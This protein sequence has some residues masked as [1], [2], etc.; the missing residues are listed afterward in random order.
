M[1]TIPDIVHTCTISW[2]WYIG[3]CIC[4]S[5]SET[6]C[7][8]GALGL[9]PEQTTLLQACR[10]VYRS[11]Q[12][13]DHRCSRAHARIQ[14]RMCI[15]YTLYSTLIDGSNQPSAHVQQGYS[16]LFVCV[17]VCLSVTILFAS[18]LSYTVWLTAQ[19]VLHQR[20]FILNCV[21]SCQVVSGWSCHLL[22]GV[23]S[24]THPAI[25]SPRSSYTGLWMKWLSEPSIILLSI[26][27]IMLGTQAHFYVTEHSSY[28]NQIF[29]YRKEL[30]DHVEKLAIRERT[31][32][33]LSQISMVISRSH[34]WLLHTCSQSWLS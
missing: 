5:C 7:S 25:R 13:W 4:E 32:S 15:P 10:K 23:V 18:L 27:V 31:D 8:H 24:H 17:C 28:R 21:C 6:P 30:W 14:G 19:R 33:L 2:L 12:I 20:C 26:V 34:S 3:L 11:G 29:Y 16:S 9:R 1:M 22:V